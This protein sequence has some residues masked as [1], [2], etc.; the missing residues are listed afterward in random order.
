MADNERD[1]VPDPSWLNQVHAAAAHTSFVFFILTPA[2][3]Y[4]RDWR[5]LGTVWAINLIFVLA[6]RF[7]TKPWM[8][9]RLSYRRHT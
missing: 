7:V 5:A 6:V 1:N 3:I 9:R 2:C 4:A 8:C